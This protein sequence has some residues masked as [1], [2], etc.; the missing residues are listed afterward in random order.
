MKTAFSSFIAFFLP[1]SI[2]FAQIPQEKAL[3]WEISGKNLKNPSYLF[4]TFHILCS[5]DIQVSQSLQ[6][7]LAASEQL[8]LELDFSDTSLQGQIMQH[9]LML[10]DS[11]LSQFFTEE[12]FDTLA[13][14]FQE[15]TGTPLQFLQRMKPYMLTSVLLVPV[16]ACDVKGWETILVELTRAYNTPIKG[17]ETVADQ[18][19]VFDAIPYRLQAE[20]LQRGVANMD[21]LR[22]AMTE[23]VS[24]YKSE[25]I[26]KM[27][28]IS[29][30]DPTLK[31]YTK[32]L[33]DNRN[34]KWIPL[35][36]REIKERSTFF[37]VGAGHLGGAS[38]VVNLLRNSGYTV[39]PVAQ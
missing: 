4:G 14:D 20:Q 25:D 9:A 29:S 11:T 6:D 37:A 21:S 31:G 38:G 26:A 35:I 17:L 28:E 33:L 19:A 12:E 36:E 2:V 22:L 27:Q 23:F 3:L 34:K 30:S 8:Y 10:N 18:M 16:F 39:S 32:V 1:L 5:E 15:L 13:K 24:L 7:R